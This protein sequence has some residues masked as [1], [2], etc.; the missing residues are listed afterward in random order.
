L[1]QL[2]VAFTSVFTI[3]LMV[4]FIASGVGGFMC[5]PWSVF[6]LVVVVVS[7]LSI[8]LKDAPG[9]SLLRLVSPLLFFFSL[10]RLVRLVNPTPPTP[11]TPD[12]TSQTSTPRQIRAFHVVGVMRIACLPATLHTPHTTRHLACLPAA[13]H[14]PNT[15][16]C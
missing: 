8:I 15:T 3:E 10:L 6:D 1:A 12:P 11:Y 2:E 7:I 13:L 14:T 4:N 9:F 16:T 5:D